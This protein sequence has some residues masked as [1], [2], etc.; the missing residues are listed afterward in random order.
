MLNPFPELL[1]LAVLGP[2]ILRVTVGIFFLFRGYINLMREQREEM[3]STLR[4]DWGPLGTF[5]VWY[6]GILQVLVGLSFIFGYLVQIGA[7]IGFLII[8]KLAYLKKKYPIIAPYS[9]ALYL[10]VAAICVSLLVT[11]AGGLAFDLPL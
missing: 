6:L 9:K 8:I 11:G 7:I 3:A 4:V 10:I 2:F 1:F 5:F